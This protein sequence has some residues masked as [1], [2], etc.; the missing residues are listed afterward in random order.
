MTKTNRQNS[1][2]ST[3][4]YHVR[5]KCEVTR[6]KRGTTEC[7]RLIAVQPDALGKSFLISVDDKFYSAYA[8]SKTS[9]EN[10]STFG[11]ELTFLTLR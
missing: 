4:F 2:P 9:D 6:Q 10:P 7:P 1:E 5:R 3:L 8:T 11:N